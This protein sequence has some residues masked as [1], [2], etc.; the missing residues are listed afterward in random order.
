MNTEVR[1]GVQ[2]GLGAYAFS[3]TIPE[4]AISSMKGLGTRAFP[5]KL[6]AVAFC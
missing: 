2:I 1:D 6:A 3:K 4:A 5:K